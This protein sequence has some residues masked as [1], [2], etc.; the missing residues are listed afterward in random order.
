MTMASDVFSGL[1]AWIANLTTAG[2]TESSVVRD[3]VEGLVILG[4]VGSFFWVVFGHLSRRFERQADVYGCKVVSCGS[5]ECPPHLDLEDA[6]ESAG[7]P[8]GGVCPVGVRIFAD[9]LS[10]VAQQ[11]GI[12]P[13]ARSWRHGSIASRIDFLHRLSASPDREAVFQRGVRNVRYALASALA[14]SL[15]LACAAYWMG[16]LR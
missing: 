4:V 11:N 6:P 12:D 5:S 7:R 2:P 14:V 8:I 9:A 3:V 15:G 13:G 10:S 16:G 1:E